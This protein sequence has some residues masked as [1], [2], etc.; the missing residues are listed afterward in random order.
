MKLGLGIMPLV[1][2]AL[3]NGTGNGKPGDSDDPPARAKERSELGQKRR[4]SILAEREIIC[5]R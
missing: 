3:G 5:S 1:Q 4:G 2:R